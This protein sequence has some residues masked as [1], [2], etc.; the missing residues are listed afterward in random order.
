M[1]EVIDI[2][3]PVKPAQANAPI[4]EPT[5][6]M[7]LTD[8]QRGNA[9][10]N[11]KNLLEQTKWS[12]V[13]DIVKGYDEL[14]KFTGIGEHLVIP[15]PDDAVG[16]ENIYDKLG[17][18]E[19]ADKYE[20][21]NESG[22]EISDELVTGF[23]AFA[24]KEGY[25]QKQLEGAI[26][27]QLDAVK[28]S[29]E[30]YK[31][32]TAERIEKNILGMKTKWGEAQYEPTITRIDDAMQKLGVLEYF[33]EIGI[34]K[35]PEI[36]NMMLTIANSE[37]E[38]IIERTEAVPQ[39]SAQQELDEIKASKPWMEKFHADHKKTVERALELSRIISQAGQ[40]KAPRT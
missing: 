18:P 34:D 10:E 30:I 8:E 36:I 13:E 4:T 37:A 6:W 15:R 35:D 33:R 25:T 16:W 19:S 38:D 23:K 29:D 21:T 9:P 26:S 3:E 24:H 28:A 2:K 11:V 12:S 14:Q 39:K 20:F 32:Q 40:G 22:V 31:T 1:T 17:R 5:S 7:P 27:F